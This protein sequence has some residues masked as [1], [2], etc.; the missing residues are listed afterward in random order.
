MKGMS[1]LE[2]AFHLVSIYFIQNHGLPPLTPTGMAKP[3]ADVQGENMAGFA[4]DGSPVIGF[5]HLHDSGTGGVSN[6]NRQMIDKYDQRWK[7]TYLERHLQWEISRYLYT[8]LV[9]TIIL[10]I[11]NSANRSEAKHMF[12]DQLLPVQ[13]SSHWTWNLAFT[14]K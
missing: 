3:V 1:L 5:S 7:L 10:R 12:L 2:R 8:H 9:E 14:P 6:W 13:D 4:S 11:A